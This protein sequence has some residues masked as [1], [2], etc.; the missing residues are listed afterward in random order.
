MAGVAS[1]VEARPRS[2][3]LRHAGRA[4]LF[5][6]GIALTAW[7]V[8]AAGAANVAR[9]LRGAGPWISLIVL[10]EAIPAAL[11]VVA[12]RLILGP[13]AH[14]VRAVTWARS[15]SLAYASTVLLPAGRA[16]GE[17]A[18]AMALSGSVGPSRAASGC[19]RL[20][21]CALA[22]NGAIATI[23][24]CAIARGGASA[25]TLALAVFANALVCGA[26]SV[27]IFSVMS[28]ARMAA[29]ARRR[30]PRFVESHVES[31]SAVGSGGRLT[32]TAFAAGLAL[33][34]R[35]IQTIQYGVVLLA[36]GGS[37]AP[38]NALRAQGVHLVG[39][40]V[41]DFVPN[42]MGATEGA[43]RAFASLLGFG[44]E[45]AR[46]IGIALVVR[47]AQIGLACACLLLAACLKRQAPRAV[48]RD[49]S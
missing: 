29:W 13:P 6:A 26:L 39:A 47:V 34:G 15:A 22:G 32:A 27:A 11:D 25:R 35:G 41:G 42:Q 9:V 45:P 40:A 36:V 46:A 3:L 23:A 30:F 1:A 33:L 19:A 14:A 24:A 43:Y 28:S 2:E 10:L 16:A 12:V 38:Q 48:V 4:L 20:Q 37:Y 44:A 49:D 7:L 17:A 31:H 18:R 21:A 8:R 5:I